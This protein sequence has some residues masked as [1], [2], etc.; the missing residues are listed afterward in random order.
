LV[1]DRG[2]LIMTDAVAPLAQGE[3]PV[4]AA[5]LG[6][7]LAML[8]APTTVLSL[9]TEEEASRVPGLARRIRKVRTFVNGET[10]EVTLFE[11]RTTASAAHLMVLGSRGHDRTTAAAL[12]ASAAQALTEDGLLKADVAIG[13]GEVS[14][15]ALH[16]S[17]IPIRLFVLPSGRIGKLFD[18]TER[19]AI[20]AFNLAN[21]E[22]IC[23][24]SM[25]ATAAHAI[26]VP[27]PT[28]GRLLEQE[29]GLSARA[30]DEPFLA[31][32]LGCD[33]PP[34][35]PESD[36]FLPARYSVKDLSGKA[37]CRKVLGK[38]HALA[39]GHRTLLLTT[40]PLRHDKGGAI[41]TA[42][43]SRLTQ[44]DVVVAIPADGDKDLVERA[45]L[46]SIE[47]PGRLAV[48]DGPTEANEHILRAGADAILLADADDRTGRAS[49]LA[50][51]YGVL[52]IALDAAAHRDFIVDYDPSSKTGT[53]ILFDSGDP[54][55]VEGA[56]R[57][58]L[59][60]KQDAEAWHPL[61]QSLMKAAPT[62]LSTAE[63]MKS[64]AA[65]LAEAAEPTNE[66]AS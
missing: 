32:R 20:D 37:E 12:L 22:M 9:G 26:V 44:L 41:V 6:R 15:L 30:S 25:G 64:L 5:G 43:L 28:A 47:A 63:H 33:D 42:A 16:N 58:A 49:G 27:S 50:Q 46:L 52:P 62:W 18:E 66:L 57:R 40:A 51:R 38:Q 10:R 3:A 29:P 2:Y 65:D 19:A 53:G 35:D 7:A 17:K 8:G 1:F 13:W 59:A 55:D 24:G 21:A 4:G 34:F 23:F 36:P 31:L 45:R 60:L 14:A 56:V 54:F 61:V 48:L 11:G 39:L